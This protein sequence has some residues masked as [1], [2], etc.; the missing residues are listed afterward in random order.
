[1]K[2]FQTG[3]NLLHGFFS[4]QSPEDIFYSMIKKL[5][6]TKLTENQDYEVSNKTWKITFGY[7]NEAY[8]PPEEEQKRQQQPKYTKVKAKFEI[9]KVPQSFNNRTVFVNFKREYG[10]AFYFYEIIKPY[11]DDLEVFNN[12]MHEETSTNQ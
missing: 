6:M 8:S 12:A 4:T 7:K 5:K 2:E 3:Q 1:M 10:D 9:L 11:I